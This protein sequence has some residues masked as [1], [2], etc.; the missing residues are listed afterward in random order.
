MIGDLHLKKIPVPIMHTNYLKCLYI[1]GFPYKSNVLFE[2]LKVARG[3][4]GFRRK[5]FEYHCSTFLLVLHNMRQS[6]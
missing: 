6:E 4:P 5:H 2:P 1:L 3:T